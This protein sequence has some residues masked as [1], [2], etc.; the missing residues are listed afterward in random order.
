MHAPC[1]LLLH[2]SLLPRAAGVPVLVDGAH[3]V[4]A[5]PGL[6]VASLGADYYTTNL[7]KW[8]CTPKV[9]GGGVR[10]RCVEVI[11]RGGWRERRLAA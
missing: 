6:D 8:L 10:G 4:G 11:E 1:P 5:L 9:R 3:A 2:L 7:H